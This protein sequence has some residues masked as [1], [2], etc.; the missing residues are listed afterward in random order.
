MY[1]YNDTITL[2]QN[3][4]SLKTDKSDFKNIYNNNKHIRNI[5]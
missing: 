3:N 4:G 1:L 5:D 2:R